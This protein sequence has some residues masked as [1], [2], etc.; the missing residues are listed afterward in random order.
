MQVNLSLNYVKREVSKKHVIH[1]VQISHGFDNE[2]SRW[3]TS[4]GHK[5]L[6]SFLNLACKV[7]LH[8][9]IKLF[10]LSFYCKIYPLMRTDFYSKF[11]AFQFCP[12]SELSKKV[13]PKRFEGFLYYLFNE[14]KYI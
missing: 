7:L 11:L 14:N 6:F 10:L 9:H 5:W 12:W 1:F 13:V 3:L 2:A 8:H 4:N